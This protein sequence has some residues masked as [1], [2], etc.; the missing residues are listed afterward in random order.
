MMRRLKLS[1]SMTAAVLVASLTAGPAFAVSCRTNASFD[2]WLDEFRREAAGA[3]ISQRALAAAA[4]GMVYDQRIVNIDRGQRVF[5]QTFIEF[6]S[7]MVA[8]Y[9]IQRGGQLMQQHGAVFARANQQFGVPAAVIT[10]FWGLES[11]F[12][13]NV[14]KEKS[15]PAITSLAYDCRRAEMFRG[16]LLSALQLIDRGDLAARGDDR[17][18]GRRDRPDPDDADRIQQM[19]GSTM[20]ATAT[21]T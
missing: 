18:V 5:N 3:G 14:G 9:R 11:D 13:A 2:R 1:F 16:H 19:G 12:G 8:A 6:S 7:R 4:P 10:A 15:L 20:T 17:L 21:A